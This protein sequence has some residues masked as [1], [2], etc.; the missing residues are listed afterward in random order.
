MIDRRTVLLA[1]VVVAS[2]APVGAY[3][4]T[5]GFRIDWQGGPQT[6]AVARSLAAQI[7]LVKALP[8]D[9]AVAA[10]F[11][12][13]VVTVDLAEGTHT[14]AGP[15]GVFFERRAMPPG[16][17]VLLHE[18]I[19]RYQLLRMPGGRD[20]PDV[21]RFYEQARASGLYPADA[22]MLSNPFEFFAMTASVVLNGRA[23]RPPFTR[24]NVAAKSPDLYRFI[25]ATFGLRA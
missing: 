1:G 13:Q 4:A 8:I 23:A 22:Y 14:R 25:V 7:A 18:L 11:A 16:N 21:R 9:P 12:D 6:P 10:F 17:P 24:A 3:A 2:L 15:R 19:H 5:E 20:N